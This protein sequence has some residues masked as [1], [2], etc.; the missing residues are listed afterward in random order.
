MRFTIERLRTLVL[1]AGVLLVIALGV[2]LGVGKFRNR[3]SKKDIPHALGLGIQEEANGFVYTHD[4]RGHTLYRIRASKQLQLKKDGKVFLQL[5]DVS[6]ELFAEDGSRVDRIEGGEFEYNPGVGIAKAMGPVEITLMKPTVAPAIAPKAAA[7]KAIG[8]KQM[9]EKLASAAQTAASGEIHV[10]TS[11]LIFNRESGEAS[12]ENKVEFSLAQGNG[13]A[14]G[15]KYDAHDGVLVLDRDVEL[16]V[17][18]GSQP[19]KMFA[20][21]AEFNRDDQA[22]TLRSATIRYGNNASSAESAKIY[23]RNDGSAKRLDAAGGFAA[24]TLTGGRLSAPRAT[25]SFDEHNEPV[26]GR[27]EGGTSID[28]ESNGRKVHGSAPWMDLVF[29]GKGVLRTA[30]LERGVQISSDEVQGAVKT[31]REWTSPVL[32]IAFRDA[33]KGKIEPA[34]MHGTGGVVVAASTQRGNGPAAPE[35]LTADEVTGEFGQHGILSAFTGHGN[36]TITQMTPAGVQQSTSGDTVIAHLGQV[37]AING[38]NSSQSGLQISSATVDGHVVLTQQPAAK[39]GVAQAAVKATAGHADYGEG[40]SWLHLTG[41]PRVSDGGLELAGDKLDVS[42][43]TGDAMARGNVKGTWNGDAERANS[44]GSTAGFGAQGPVHVVAE[45]AELKRSSGA[46][47]FKGSVRLW[48]EG[49]SIA[50]PVIVLDRTKQTLTAQTSSAKTPVRVVLVSAMAVIPGEQ[51]KPKQTESSVITVSGGDLK[52]SGAERKAVMKAGATGSVVA[53]TADAKTTSKEVEL[54]LLPAGNRARNGGAT[55]QV[56]RMTSRGHV[57]VSSAGRRGIGEQLVYSNDT[58]DFVLTGTAVAPPQL[59]DPAHGTV[60]GQA[61]IFNS[62]NDSVRV[63][64]EGLKTMTTTK[65]PK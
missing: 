36:T 54:V 12:T 65:A 18:R 64:G 23:F 1:V 40:G 49:N 52:Y 51:T 27:L 5:H 2:F 35:K 57:E 6:I 37:Q 39:K 42:Q 61:L 7:G 50:A 28:S 11:G 9:P 58:G 34:S 30:H 19:L 38:K 46:A 14:V 31:H 63:D 16:N 29:T 56:D 15:A 8:S 41:N 53:N 13:S 44:S 20:R 45:E 47:T 32:D 43:E 10:K 48:Q 25:L 21:H 22:C 55:G 60:T 62:R 26:R 24:T 17:E 33:G 4:V 59:I 3:F